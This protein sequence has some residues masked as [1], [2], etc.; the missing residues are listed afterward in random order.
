MSQAD[1]ARFVGVDR[2]TVNRWENGSIN[3][4]RK[5]IESIC[6]VLHLDPA[7][8]CHPNEVVFREERV[9]IDYWRDADPYTQELVR[10]TLGMKETKSEE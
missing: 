10:R 6:N 3:I 1:V 2:A 4:D 7:I 5:H 8:F 9:L